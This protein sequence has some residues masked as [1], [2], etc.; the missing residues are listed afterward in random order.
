V[1]KGDFNNAIRVLNQA[2]ALLR[3]VLGGSAV[4]IGH[5]LLSIAAVH[6][7]RSEED[8]A[9]L[10]SYSEALQ[11]FRTNLGEEDILFALTVNNIGVRR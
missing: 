8:A 10:A 4:E 11:P 7:A 3:R 2:I 6:D 5:I 9:A 1:E